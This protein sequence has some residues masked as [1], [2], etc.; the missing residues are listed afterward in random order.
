MTIMHLKI[1]I[2]FFLIHNYLIIF[3][4][5]LMIANIIIHKIAIT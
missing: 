5:K 3:S 2:I 4:N 1:I